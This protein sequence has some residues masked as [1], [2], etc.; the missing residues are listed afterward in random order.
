MVPN[1]ATVFERLPRVLRRHRLMK[2]WMSLTGEDP[3]QLV[4][5]RDHSFGYADLSD[6]FLRLIIIDG[7]FEEEFFLMADAL[8]FN[9]GTF[10]DVGANYGLLSFGLAGRHGDRVQF[11]IF[12]PNEYLIA[13]IKRTLQNYPTMRAKLNVIAVSDQVGTASFFVDASQTG[14]SHITHGYGVTVPTLTLDQYLEQENL[15]TV[16]LLK[17]DIE[18]YE[19]AALQGAKNSLRSRRFRAIYFECFEKLLVRFGARDTL[20]QF[21]SEMDYQVCFCR[22]SDIDSR[23]G[24][25]HTISAGLAGH[26]IPL[27]PING[28]SLPAMTDLLAVPSENLSLG[29]AG[30]SELGV[31]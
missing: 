6:G 28:H 25:T 14:A 1:A 4:R 10:L 17:L 5:I 19:L 24:A 11:H 16:D 7:H 31:R 29:R 22:S 9:G 15:G 26:G 18:G 21:L 8:L 27:L 2:A 3:V 13:S 12:E 20:L 30:V 23:G